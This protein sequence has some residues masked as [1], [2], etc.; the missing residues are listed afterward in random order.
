[1]LVG[2]F[3]F[4]FS[5]SFS[6]VAYD[7]VSYNVSEFFSGLVKELNR[8]VNLNYVGEIKKGEYD[9]GKF[10][11]KVVEEKKEDFSVIVRKINDEEVLVSKHV[12]PD[13]IEE[14]YTENIVELPMFGITA[15]IHKTQER[16]EKVIYKNLREG[17]VLYPG[18]DEPGLGYS[19]IIGHSASYS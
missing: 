5:V 12:K 15:P 4:L 8:P 14:A 13:L 9:P 6:F 18:S 2:L 10:V 3:V 16:D 1:L 11:E 17:V 7:L 19:L